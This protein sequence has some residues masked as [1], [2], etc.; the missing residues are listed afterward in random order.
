MSFLDL[1]LDI[2][3][4]EMVSHV[5]FKIFRILPW[6]SMHSLFYYQSWAKD[7]LELS[8]Y[9]LRLSNAFTYIDN[10]C[11]ESLDDFLVLAGHFP[12]DFVS[13]VGDFERFWKPVVRH[14]SSLAEFFKK[15]D[16]DH[17]FH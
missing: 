14:K 8:P 7:L 2:S 15:P 16:K 9:P 12:K 6:S 10:Y 3:L 1:N 11:R 5:N 13:L 17:R 4:E